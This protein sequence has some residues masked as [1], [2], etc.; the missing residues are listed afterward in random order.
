M[1]RAMDKDKA[2]WLLERLKD[3]QTDTCSN[4]RGTAE[5]VALDMAIEE[6]RFDLDAFLKQL[7]NTLQDEVNE[8]QDASLLDYRAGLYYAIDLLRGYME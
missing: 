7:V 5:E 3:M 8:N 1:T 4:L 6:L 2:I